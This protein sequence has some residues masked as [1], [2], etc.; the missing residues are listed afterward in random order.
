MNLSLMLLTG[1]RQVA[2]CQRVEVA[3]LRCRSWRVLGRSSLGLAGRQCSAGACSVH[4]AANILQLCRRFVNTAPDR[5]RIS[6]RHAACDCC[7]AASV[8]ILRLLGLSL[9]DA[10]GSS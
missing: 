5:G 10:R 7:C 3:D 2:G 8:S 9:P 6:R 1:L 4:L